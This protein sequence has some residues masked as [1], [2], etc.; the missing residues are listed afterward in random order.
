MTIILTLAALTVA[1]L[2]CAFAAYNWGKSHKIQADALRKTLNEQ[3]SGII[4]HNEIVDKLDDLQE[5]QQH[6]F[7]KHKRPE[8]LHSRNAFDNNGMFDPSPTSS[9]DQ[10]TDTSQTNTSSD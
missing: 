8:V 9:Q 5:I 7:E 6:E 1:A 10:N 4:Q 2:A 3:N